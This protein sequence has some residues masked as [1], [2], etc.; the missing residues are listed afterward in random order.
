MSVVAFPGREVR[1]SA[2]LERLAASHPEYVAASAKI[3]LNDFVRRGVDRAEAQAGIRSILE[4]LLPS[5][6]LDEALR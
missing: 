5:A 6:T 1:E 4:D 3:M 2:R